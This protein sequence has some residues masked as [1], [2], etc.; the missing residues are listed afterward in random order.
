MFFNFYL[1]ISIFIILMKDVAK[2]YKRWMEKF[3]HGMCLFYNVQT[4][5]WKQHNIYNTSKRHWGET[6]A[7]SSLWSLWRTVNCFKRE[8]SVAKLDFRGQILILVLLVHIGGK[9]SQKQ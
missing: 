5:S 8:K 2:G 9:K 1:F 3:L 6:Y 7:V 4:L